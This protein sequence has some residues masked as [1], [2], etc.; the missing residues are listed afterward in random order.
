MLLVSETLVVLENGAVLSYSHLGT[1]A[2][3]N[4]A[5]LPG[6]WRSCLFWPHAAIDLADKGS[7]VAVNLH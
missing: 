1:L 3:P 2:S 4:S 6:E 7:S 5:K